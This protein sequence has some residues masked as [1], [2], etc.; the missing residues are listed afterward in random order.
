MGQI[1]NIEEL[2]KVSYFIDKLKPVTKMEVNY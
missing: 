2:D 1:E